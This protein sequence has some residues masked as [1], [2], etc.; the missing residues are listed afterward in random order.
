MK[1]ATEHLQQMA[2]IAVDAAGKAA[3]LVTGG[4][5]NLSALDGMLNQGSKP[6]SDAKADAASSNGSAAKA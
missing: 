6:P 5:S 2:Q 1:T 4:A 3:P